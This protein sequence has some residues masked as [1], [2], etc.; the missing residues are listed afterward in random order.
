MFLFQKLR[1]QIAFPFSDKGRR[2]FRKCSHICHFKPVY[3]TRELGKDVMRDQSIIHKDVTHLPKAKNAL[4]FKVHQ[5]FFM[6]FSCFIR[7]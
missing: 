6:K 3:M 2:T 5:Q 1:N 4:G 7:K